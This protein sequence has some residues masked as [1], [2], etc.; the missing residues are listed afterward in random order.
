MT[1]ACLTETNSHSYNRTS[2]CIET[3][4]STTLRQCNAL[5]TNEKRKW[6][7][8]GRDQ[9]NQNP[10]AV[11]INYL[12]TALRSLL[13]NKGF[14]ILNGLGLA[15]GIATCL[16][17]VFYVMDELSYDR[18]NEKADR[19][20]R[21]NNMIRFGGNENVY[22]ASP[23]PAAQV[24]KNDFPEIEQVV[25]MQTAGRMRI[26]K[27][28]QYIQEDHIGY[29]DSSLF[30]V[31]TLPMIDGNPATALRNPKSVVITEE[32]AKKYFSRTD[33]V[34][35]TFTRDNGD[36][37]NI[38]GVIRDIPTQSHFR[39]DFFFSLSTLAASRDNAWLTNN[40]N[41]YV[42]LK[43]G[44]DPNRL[45]AKFP[46]FVRKYMSPQL[47]DMLHLTFDAFEKSGNYYRM[48]LFPLTKNSSP[49]QFSRRPGPKRQ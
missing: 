4:R 19:I 36:L 41:T 9:D 32:T 6:H 18:F 34:G 13:K 38:T 39:F 24:L 23:A 12:K 37:Y 47:Q 10:P 46:G 28:S 49:I 31:F 8:L 1:S 27:G 29:A 2:Q 21:V 30:S 5:I 20:Y 15:L 16:L 22:A 48:G 43:P 7:Y 14:T 40:F 45:N 3:E 35:R 44:T 17:I 25:R 33:V 42:L 11:F 26:K